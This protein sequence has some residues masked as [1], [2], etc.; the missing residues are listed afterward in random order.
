MRKEK[1]YNR[2]KFTVEVIKEA[3]VGGNKKDPSIGR[4]GSPKLILD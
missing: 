3:F 1:K 2:V 4:G